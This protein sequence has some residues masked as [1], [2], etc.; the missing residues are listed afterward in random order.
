MKRQRGPVHQGQSVMEHRCYV[1]GQLE[2]G[3]PG[4]AE[5]REQLGERQAGIVIGARELES[6]DKQDVPASTVSNQRKQ[7]RTGIFE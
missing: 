2:Y 1:V 3:H 6:I 7:R 4:I 5:E